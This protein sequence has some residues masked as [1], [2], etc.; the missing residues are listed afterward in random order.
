MII[1]GC[2]WAHPMNLGKGTQIFWVNNNVAQ[3]VLKFLIGLSS[4]PMVISGYVWIN[5]IN[6]GSDTQNIWVKWL[7]T[8]VSFIFFLFLP[9]NFYSETADTFA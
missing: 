6:L 8:L 3:N 9:N 7:F 2:L 1:I 5:P 4:Y